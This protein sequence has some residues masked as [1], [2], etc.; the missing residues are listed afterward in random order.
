MKRW[1]F[2]KE[3]FVSL[4]PTLYLLP[5]KPRTTTTTA[6]L[7]VLI[8]SIVDREFAFNVKIKT[9]AKRSVTISVLNWCRAEKGRQQE[10]LHLSGEC[11]IKYGNEN[12]FSNRL[13]ASFTLSRHIPVPSHELPFLLKTRHEE[14]RLWKHHSW[15]SYFVPALNFVFLVRSTGTYWDTARADLE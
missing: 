9:D 10:T 13:S 11:E 5:F 14:R 1:A 12:D 2:W 8:F 15:N 4:H 7:F 6:A 3:M